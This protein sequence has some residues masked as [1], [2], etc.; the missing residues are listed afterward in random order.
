MR[1]MVYTAKLAR[2]EK[3]RRQQAAERMRGLFADLT[4]NRNLSDELVA[5][6]RAEAR[7]EDREADEEAGRIR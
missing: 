2:L 3:E 6:R 7:A 4:P 1:C 5:E